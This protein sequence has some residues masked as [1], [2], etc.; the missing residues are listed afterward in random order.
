MNKILKLA[1]VAGTVLFAVPSYGMFR[2][3]SHRLYRCYYSASV[4]C[5]LPKT[6]LKK[7]DIEKKIQIITT[8]KD[9]DLTTINNMH[10]ALLNIDPFIPIGFAECNMARVKVLK[11]NKG[12]IITEIEFSTNQQNMDGDSRIAMEVYTK[13]LRSTRIENDQREVQRETYERN[14]RRRILRNKLIKNI[15]NILDW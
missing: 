12:L 6:I 11:L 2:R 14:K 7:R 1:L 5:N 10:Y 15:K 9:M 8:G 13:A 4:I 3:L